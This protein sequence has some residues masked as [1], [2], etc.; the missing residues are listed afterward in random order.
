MIRKFVLRTLAFLLLGSSLA[1]QGKVSKVY[2]GSEDN[3]SSKDM[4]DMLRGTNC[5]SK[6]CGTHDRPCRESAELPRANR[7]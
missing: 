2:V 6:I 1:A 7:G 3:K 4:G 5:D